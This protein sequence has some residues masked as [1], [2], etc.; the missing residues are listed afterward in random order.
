MAFPRVPEKICA[1]CGLPLPDIA[2]N[3]MAKRRNAPLVGLKL[4]RFER[5]RSFAIYEMRLYARS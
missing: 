2:R 4:T 3:L 1:V 5:A